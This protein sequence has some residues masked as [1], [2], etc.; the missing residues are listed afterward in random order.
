MTPKIW[1]TEG[2]IGKWEYS[3]LKGFSA[4]MEAINIVKG[5]KGELEVLVKQMFFK[6]LIY[7]TFIQRKS[8]QIYSVRTR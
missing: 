7:K 3:K 2:K 6:G 8:L 5:S 1:A 4:A